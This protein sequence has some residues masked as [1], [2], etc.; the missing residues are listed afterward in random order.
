MD[1]TLSITVKNHSDII[2]ARMR[3]RNLARGAGLNTADQ[4]RI[5]LATSSLAQTLRM[6]ERHQGRIDVHFLK[7]EAKRTGVHVVCLLIAPEDCAPALNALKDTKWMLMVD[8]LNIETLPSK[9]VKVT[10]I[11]WAG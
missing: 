5:S 3:V 9:D 6:G 2:Q 8:E 7:D 11:K 4:A 10:A 1:D